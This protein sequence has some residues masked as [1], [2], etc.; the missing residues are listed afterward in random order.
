MASAIAS[1]KL[2]VLPAARGSKTCGSSACCRLESARR[3]TGHSVWACGVGSTPVEDGMNSSSCVA[4]RSR[5]SALLT[6]GW[7]MASRCAARVT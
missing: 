3:T 7:V 2:T 5:R 6:A 4:S 1:V